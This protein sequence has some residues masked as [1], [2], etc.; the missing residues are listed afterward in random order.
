MKLPKIFRDAYNKTTRSIIQ[1][2]CRED[3]ESVRKMMGCAVG[4]SFDAIGYL[5]KM[6]LQQHGLHQKT[7][8][9]DV[10]CGAGRLLSQLNHGDVRSYLGIDISGDLLDYS[11]QFLHGPDWNLT[12]VNSCEI[13]ADDE[14]CDMVCMFSVITHLL[15]QESYR[16]FQEAARVLRPG[17]RLIVSFLEFRHPGLWPIFEDSVDVVLGGERLDMFV[18][19]EGLKLWAD[20]SGLTVTALLDGEKPHIVIDR[21]IVFENGTRVT[22]MARLGPTGQSVAVMEKRRNP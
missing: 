5:E 11:R 16:Y 22:G 6:L 19:R 15:H 2:S 18:D 3:G 14:S 17:G 10:G 4:G 7:D 8:L 20:H 21:E 13:P 12:L 9:I 1:G